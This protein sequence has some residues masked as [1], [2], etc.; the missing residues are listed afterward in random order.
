MNNSVPPIR[1]V[2]VEDNADFCEEL[3]FLLGK[4]GMEV[5]GFP[6]ARGLDK[7]LLEHGCDVLVLDVGLPGESGLSVANRMHKLHDIAIIMLTARDRVEDKIAGLEQGADVYLVKPVDVRELIAVIR[8]QSRRRRDQD[9]WRLNMTDL[10]LTTPDRQTISLS[11]QERDFLARL[12]RTPGKA[13]T[14]RDMIE[15]L[16]GDL[17]SYDTRR[18][19]TLVSRLR[20]KL[21]DAGHSDLVQTVY[22]T[23]YLVTAQLVLAP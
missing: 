16:G 23:G 1:V 14:R 4:S 22:G 7:H 3:V 11:L 15:A 21:E 19:E 17:A 2:L 10:A 20:R 5:V 12:A 8:S 13:V 6:D 18:L 9:H